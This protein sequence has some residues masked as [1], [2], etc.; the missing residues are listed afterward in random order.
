M[1]K[2][3]IPSE[4]EQRIEGYYPAYEVDNNMNC[5]G[6]YEMGRLS[7]EF[8]KQWNKDHYNWP[9]NIDLWFERKVYSTREEAWSVAL[10]RVRNQ[11]SDGDDG[12]DGNYPILI[13]LVVGDHQTEPLRELIKVQKDCKFLYSWRNPNTDNNLE[14]YLLTNGSE[15]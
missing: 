7:C 8:Q 12:E 9:R 4:E 5:C 1:D 2:C 14:M 6:L 15:G 11:V 13:T 3:K 10:Q